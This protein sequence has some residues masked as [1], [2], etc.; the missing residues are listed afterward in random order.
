[1]ELEK[2]SFHI[3]IL[4]SKFQLQKAFSPQEYIGHTANH[5]PLYYLI[6]ACFIHM[7][8]SAHSAKTKIL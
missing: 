5:P 4:S 8:E 2:G 6:H 1:M 7:A 3:L